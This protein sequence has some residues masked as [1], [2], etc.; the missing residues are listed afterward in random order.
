MA[1]KRFVA[2]SRRAL[3]VVNSNLE[4]IPIGLVVSG[5]SLASVEH[6]LRS[7]PPPRATYWDWLYGA[8][9]NGPGTSESTHLGATELALVQAPPATAHADRRWLGFMLTSSMKSPEPSFIR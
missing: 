9:V 8:Q 3:R 7:W 5:Q 6:P 2:T 4:P 1:K